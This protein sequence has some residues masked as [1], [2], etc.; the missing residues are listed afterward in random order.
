MENQD[1]E[2]DIAYV[3]NPGNFGFNY[4]YNMS[5]N[6]VQNFYLVLLNKK[7]A[8]KFPGFFSIRSLRSEILRKNL[9]KEQDKQIKEKRTRS[10]RTVRTT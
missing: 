6:L 8:Q 1:Y 5:F 2:E 9:I 4:T 10:Q 3:I 7:N